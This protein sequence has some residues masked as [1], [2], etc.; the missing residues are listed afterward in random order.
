MQEKQYL[1]A[2]RI[3][4][5]AEKSL[6]NP[7]LTEVGALHVLREKM[8]KTKLHLQETLVTELQNHLYLKTKSSLKRIG[9]P[10]PDVKNVRVDI[11]V[12]SPTSDM[13][14][15]KKKVLV[16]DEALNNL[17]SDIDPYHQIQSLLEGLYHL[18]QLEESLQVHDI[19]HSI[20]K[21]EF[22][23]NCTMWWIE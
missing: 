12:G 3:L 19:D 13:L 14:R 2:V 23:L 21:N 17:A 20:S 22:P 6:N 18:G 10:I 15:F 11:E 16:D 5:G 1:H 7:D 9:Q 8:Q 4:R